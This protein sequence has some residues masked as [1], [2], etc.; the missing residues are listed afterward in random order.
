MEKHV[1]ATEAVR[2][3]SEI[4]NSV[5]YRGDRYVI[6]R[7]KKPVAHIYPHDEG[8]GHKTLGDLKSLIKHLPP[9]ED[10]RFADD[11]K[12]SIQEQPLPPSDATWE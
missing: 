4:L 8:A 11:V 9:L 6:M 7:G 3:F 10:K 2:R 5:N 1:T 12:K